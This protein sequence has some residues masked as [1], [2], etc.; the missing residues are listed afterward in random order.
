MSGENPF[1]PDQ[2]LRGAVRFEWLDGGHF[3]LQRWHIEPS[4]FPSGIAVIG[5][6]GPAGTLA[7][8]YY[9]SRGVSRT[10]GVTLE[11][12]V[13]TIARD[14]PDF[15]QRFVGRFDDDGATIAGAWERCD[16]GQHWQHDFALTYARKR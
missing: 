2:P 1:D 3:L 4:I 14:D 5:A 15:A 13:L 9:D 16:D 7:Q 8:H 12:G 11:D 10:Y 6:D